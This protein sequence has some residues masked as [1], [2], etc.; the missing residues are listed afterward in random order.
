MTNLIAKEGV[1]KQHHCIFHVVRAGTCFNSFHIRL[2]LGRVNLLQGFQTTLLAMELQQPC[3]HRFR[4]E[5]PLLTAQPPRAAIVNWGTSRRR[6]ACLRLLIMLAS[7]QPHMVVVP[8]FPP[9]PCFLRHALP[10]C[11][12]L[13]LCTS[14]LHL[15][16]DK[17]QHRVTHLLGSAMHLLPFL[18]KSKICS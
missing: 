7:L 13:L 15:A 18:P 2:A 1:A 17:V 6:T 4:F 14:S 12:V 11:D 8:S 3:F 16:S 10:R 5:R 9:C